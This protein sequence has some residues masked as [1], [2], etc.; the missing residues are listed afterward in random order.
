MTGKGLWCI[1][2]LAGAA[3]LAG[4]ARLPAAPAAEGLVVHEWGTFL[5]M[6]GSDGVTLDGMYHEEHALPSFV[7][8]RSRD[9]LHLPSISV[10]GETPVIYFYTDRKQNVSVRVDFP[11]GVWT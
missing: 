11:Q 9:Q 10:K 5:T 8:A 3:A 4:A 1:S 7:H 6:Q 2:L